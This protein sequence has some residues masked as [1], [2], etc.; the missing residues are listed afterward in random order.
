VIRTTAVRYLILVVV[1]LFAVIVQVRLS[2]AT[3][4]TQQTLDFYVPFLLEPFTA[5]AYAVDRTMNW[6]KGSEAGARRL[7]RSVLRED[8]RVVKVNGRPLT[9]LSLYLAEL[10]NHEHQ[11]Q[12][13][14]GALPFDGFHVTVLTKH[15]STREIEFQFP[16]CTCGA[17]APLESTFFWAV[18][19]IFCICMGAL[20]A[21]LR[22]RSLLAWAFF[23]LM[24]SLSQLQ[25]WDDPYPGFQLTINPMVWSDSM[26]VPAVAY[27]SLVQHLWPFALAVAA[28]H[29]ACRRGR[30]HPLQGTLVA[31]LL[32]LAIAKASVAVAWSEG[33][34]WMSPVY[35]LFE[36]YGSEALA[37]L[38]LLVTGA[39]WASNRRIG[40]VA[41]VITLCAV[42]ALFLGPAP[43]TEGEWKSYP[44]Q[45]RRFMLVIPEF[46]HT[47]GM[48]LVASIITFVLASCVLFRRQLSWQPALAVV[49]C[50]PL[51]IHVLASLGNWWFPFGGASLG[52]WRWIAVWAM[53]LGIVLPSFWVARQESKYPNPMR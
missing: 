3:V 24:L 4:H 37:M 44:N 13:V 10:W 39:V 5:K 47:P 12:K 49:L 7:N 8:D 25:T 22:P 17:P 1:T 46:H 15:G 35:L 45:T 9:G 19:P 26:R 32:L 36:N 34:Q 33:V 52:P 18:G 30:M 29:L 40:A 6:V 42:V 16:H 43:I 20:T 21:A 23:G 31:V 51:A 38:F 48:I 41:L 27:R 14:R 50:L 11:H 53:G 28:T 2:L